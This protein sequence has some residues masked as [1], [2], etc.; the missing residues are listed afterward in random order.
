MSILK[1]YFV[2]WFDHTPGGAGGAGR[3]P[4]P[5]DPGQKSNKD[6]LPITAQKS[7]TDSCI[8]KNKHCV[9]IILLD[10]KGHI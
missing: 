3:P 8:A 1:S 2:Y 5:C 10:R 9:R 4:P 6:P 7:Q